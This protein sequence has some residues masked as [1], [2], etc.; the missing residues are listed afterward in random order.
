MNPYAKSFHL[1][2]VSLS[3]EIATCVSKCPGFR[4]KVGFPF[5]GFRKLLYCCLDCNWNQ[6]LHVAT[7]YC[8]SEKTVVNTKMVR[9]LNV[10][11]K[12]DA[13]KNLAE[14]MS[15]GRYNRRDGFSIYNKIYEFD[16]VLNGEPSCMVM[17]SV[18]GHLLNHE[19][20]GI[21]RKWLGCSPL[22]LFDAPVVKGCSQDMEPIKRTLERE[23]RAASRLIIWT[24]CDREG[25]NIGFEIID[26]CKA[27]KPSLKVLRA[28][29]SEI[30]FPSVQRALQSLG[31]PDKR[32]S[33]AVD[34]RSELD[35]RI[36][37]AFTRFQTLRL[38]KVFPQALAETLISYGSCQFPTLGFVVERYKA[39][40]QFIPE[41]FW[42]IKVTH[43]GEEGVIDFSW[44]RVRLF[45]RLACQVLF[46]MCQDDPQAKV[47][48][49]TTKNKSKWRPLPLDTVELEKLASRK[50]RINAKETM[51]IAEKMY[52]QGYISYPRTETNIFPKELDLR[53][54]VE[55][56]TQDPNW[57]GFAAG[58]LEEGPHPRQG[59][60]SDQA[61]P[62]IHPTKYTNSL[63]GNE[64]K[65][66]EFIVRHFLACISKD[67]QGLETTVEIEIAGEGFTASGLI[68]LERNYLDVY[69]Y[70]RWSD[71]VMPKYEQ[72]QVF[73][74]TTLDM[75]DGETSPPAL[76]TEA[77]L[78]A[79]MEKH[80]IGTDATHADHIETIKSRMY[81]GLQDMR[82]VPGQLGMGL[83]EGYDSMGFQM[84]K[85][86]LRAEL[87]A[88]LKRICIGA[89]DPKV[90][91]L[92]Q[93]TK[94]RDVFEE[95]LRQAGKI[96][97]ALAQFLN[98][99]PQRRPENEPIPEIP[100]FTPICKCSSCGC[101]VVVKEKRDGGRYFVTCLGF[102]Q[103]RT[104]LWL[105]ET[106]QN[107]TVCEQ[108]CSQCNGS[109]KKLLFKF[110]PRSYVPYL[111]DEYEACLG[112][113]DQH[114]LDTLDIRSLSIYT[115]AVTGG[116]G[117]GHSSQD[118]N[119]DTSSDSGYS[120]MQMPIIP[121]TNQRR[122]IFGQQNISNSNTGIAGNMDRNNRS[123]T[124]W[125]ASNSDSRHQSSS[126][127]CVAPN[128][129]HDSYG[130]AFLN[131]SVA[132]NSLVNNLDSG[133]SAFGSSHSQFRP[134]WNGTTNDDR[135]NA[136]VCNCNEDA[137]MLTV[138]KEGPN[139]GRQFYK[140]PK[141]QGGGCA[142][143]LWADD[144][145]N[146]KSR[147]GSHRGGGGGGGKGGGW[148]ARDGGG[149]SI[150]SSGWNRGLTSG[151]D[152]SEREAV[153]VVC[154]CAIPA[155]RYTVHK[156]GPNKGRDFYT[157]SKDRSEQ[158]RFFKWADEVGDDADGG[159]T[160]N[161]WN[162]DSGFG[163][164]QGRS[165]G[166]MKRKAPEGN[167]PKKRKCGICGEEGHNR[168]NC[169]LN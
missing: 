72:G 94:Y 14:I 77:D 8:H 139:T 70:D 101:D 22:Q 160:G 125:N 117:T 64:Q 103:C 25:E 86:N 7:R 17:T 24:D 113:C 134:S 10:A 95:A 47:T 132:S 56:Q 140:C 16:M 128:R 156:E 2:K 161:T 133:F 98:E 151:F 104:T 53:P 123:S 124:I 99:E 112:G 49:I 119:L 43:A 143:F 15:R 109:P 122:I 116:Q 71:K 35:L 142:F 59:K 46:E 91:L 138:R 76:L 39:I 97:E 85:P 102:P 145:E 168:K 157:C 11:E 92:E 159:G 80:G 52:T 162:N 23:A 149:H 120:S 163:R 152:G 50:L 121:N 84:S 153:S 60:K 114:F 129:G 42:K 33:D 79:L 12:N 69:P 51:K 62:P 58:V 146:T 108:S 68:I 126:R 5:T 83:V 131:S 130:N 165:S 141:P 41:P 169:P 20:T 110:R 57:G 1:L 9:I 38:Q 111:P 87:E 75:V 88:D 158:C 65:I 166:G 144:G 147:E 74:P 90:V 155:R 106:V 63:H 67:A 21:Y 148:G 93:V 164:G 3:R 96:D 29:F 61:H 100:Q 105:P 36:G 107:I 54:L 37:A 118:R 26:V 27:V 82:F 78:I 48:K 34:V 150:S 31:A 167:K 137:I 66:Y 30:T 127:S 154:N 40:Q 44:R 28:K 32:Q 19:F 136:I 89:K 6:L 73:T 135:E 81:V 13:A 55:M 18:S 4:N 45:D 115:T